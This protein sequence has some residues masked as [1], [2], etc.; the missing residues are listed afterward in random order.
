MARF[1]NRMMNFLG[2][3]DEEEHSAHNETETEQGT[4]GPSMQASPVEEAS[5]GNKKTNI[6]SL[7]HAQKQV[8]V[9]LCEPV[10]YDESTQIAD[11]LRNRRPVILNLHKC[12]HDQSIRIIDFLSGT[13]YAMNG[14]MQKLGQNVFM[15]APENV[16][17]QGNITDTLLSIQ[18][19]N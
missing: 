2:L 5:M 9:V 6:V 10:T 19:H 16:D 1:M 14:T 15:C 17:I 7:H 4:H 3:S 8:K 18:N 11:H 12:S 13:I